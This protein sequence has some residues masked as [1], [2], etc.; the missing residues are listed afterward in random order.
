ML[1]SSSTMAM[2]MR[3]RRSRDVASLQPFP[4]NQD[5]VAIVRYNAWCTTAARSYLVYTLDIE[6]T[7][8]NK[9]I[10]TSRS[11]A[12]EIIARL[13]CHEVEPSASAQSLASAN[14]EV[15]PGDSMPKRCTSRGTPCS[16]GPSSMKSFAASSGPC[17]FGRTPA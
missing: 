15:R 12:G 3:M 14:D 11:V 6:S 17:T 16:L 2:R 5:N 10:D 8:A 4:H 1:V 13:M 7:Y 9:M